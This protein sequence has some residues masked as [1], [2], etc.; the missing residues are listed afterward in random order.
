MQVPE[1]PLSWSVINEY[2]VQLSVWFPCC[3]TYS[4]FSIPLLAQIYFFSELG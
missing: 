3:M 1:G 4:K 2:P